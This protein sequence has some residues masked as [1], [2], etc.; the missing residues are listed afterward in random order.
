MILKIV[1]MLERLIKVKYLNKIILFIIKI[2]NIRSQNLDYIDYI[3]NNLIGT[4]FQQNNSPFIKVAFL[5]NST[6]FSE[7]MFVADDS[8]NI[9][10]L[11][12]NVRSGVKLDNIKRSVYMIIKIKLKYI[13]FSTGNIFSDIYDYA[14]LESDETSKVIYFEYNGIKYDKI[15]DIIRYENY[16]DKTKIFFK[17]GDQ[18][19]SND[20]TN[21]LIIM[22]HFGVIVK[23][24]GY[25]IP[26]ESL[27]YFHVVQS[28]SSNFGKITNEREFFTKLLENP[29]VKINELINTEL[30]GSKINQENCKD[31]GDEDDEGEDN[32]KR[33]TIKMSLKTKIDSTK[34]IQEK[35]IL[36]ALFFSE[37][38]FNFYF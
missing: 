1:K 36:L 30:N 38:L 15:K 21:Y 34:I 10:T 35:K 33:K 27:K 18:Q 20:M 26:N 6:D 22:R 19:I 12:R 14:I 11:V 5:G 3:F 4:E 2:M 31:C 23:N 28:V 7:K 37:V 13:H 25:Y 8:K 9:I 29:V 16:K 24:I 32:G 17:Q